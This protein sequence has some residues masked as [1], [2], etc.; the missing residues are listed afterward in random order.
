MKILLIFQLSR[1]KKAK[2][3]EKFI[4]IEKLFWTCS[5]CFSNNKNVSFVTCFVACTEHFPL[6]IRVLPL[7]ISF[8]YSKL[9]H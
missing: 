9:F 7:F 1:Q 6:K 8:N 4:F 3:V 2:E 5:G